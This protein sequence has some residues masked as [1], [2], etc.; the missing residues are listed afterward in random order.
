MSRTVSIFSRALGDLYLHVGIFPNLQPVGDFGRKQDH[1]AVARIDRA[2]NKHVNGASR[3]GI[4]DRNAFAGKI[5]NRAREH[6]FWHHPHVRDNR[7]S[8]QRRAR[9]LLGKSP[10]AEIKLFIPPHP[11]KKLNYKSEIG[12]ETLRYQ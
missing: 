6:A 8:I 10:S 11:R 12:E 5:T 4:G 2:K 1:H 7:A 9:H 3:G